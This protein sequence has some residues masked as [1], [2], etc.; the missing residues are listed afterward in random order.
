MIETDQWEV[1]KT[2]LPLEAPRPLAKQTAIVSHSRPLM[3]QQASVKIDRP[4][5]EVFEYTNNEVAE[6]SL[7]VVEHEVLEELPQDIGSTFRCLTEDRGRQMEFHGVVTRHEPPRVSASRLTGEYFDIDVE[8]RFEEFGDTTRVTQ[9]ST[10]F[11]KGAL[12]VVF[13]LFGWM[14]RK[15]SCK[16]AEKEMQNLKRLL[17]QQP[18]RP[19]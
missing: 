10:V 17:E 15:S 16:A 4:I 14:M 12:K 5:D 19:R 7:T 1:G 13:W 18:A 3:K 11:P 9:Q 6:W 8:Y 2:G